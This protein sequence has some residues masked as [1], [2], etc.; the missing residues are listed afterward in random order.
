MADFKKKDPQRGPGVSIEHAKPLRAPLLEESL[1]GET[2]EL[3][4][5]LS[6][7]AELLTAL[8]ERIEADPAFAAELKAAAAEKPELFP[9]AIAEW[10]AG[11]EKKN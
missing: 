10:L 1:R 9:T 2:P 11:G 8:A 5:L 6:A 7:E 4:E 3:P